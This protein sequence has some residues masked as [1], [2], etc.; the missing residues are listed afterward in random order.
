MHV[1]ML[2]YGSRAAPPPPRLDRHNFPQSARPLVSGNDAGAVHVSR[3]GN[4]A[5]GG[6][7]MHGPVEGDGPR[8]D[9]GG[10]RFELNF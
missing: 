6:V 1:N 3:R 9:V 8:L 7:A 2:R 4:D 10:A 5:V